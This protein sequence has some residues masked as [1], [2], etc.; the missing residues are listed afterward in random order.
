MLT[1]SIGMG[2]TDVTEHEP[3]YRGTSRSIILTGLQLLDNLGSM[4]EQ[5]GRL[6]AALPRKLIRAIFDHVDSPQSSYDDV[7]DFIRAAAHSQLALDGGSVQDAA[8]GARPRPNDVGTP[9]GE[10][11]L[12]RPSD[13]DLEIAPAA[14]EQALSFL[15]NRLG[16]LTA[17]VR[18]ISNLYT[19]SG[20]PTVGSVLAEVPPVVRRFALTLR[21]RDD[22]ERVPYAHR[23]S[24][25][26][27]AGDDADKSVTRFCDSYLLTE[28]GHGPLVD[29]GLASVR[30]GRV[31]L[32]EAG[33]HVAHSLSPLFD[34]V[35]N[36][37]SIGP[38]A[39]DGLRAALL[40][41]LDEVYE[42]SVVLATAVRNPRQG[43]VDRALTEAHPE[44]TETAIASGRAALLGRLRDLDV[45]SVT[46]RG[47]AASVVPLASAVEFI[48]H[49][50]R[51]AGLEAVDLDEGDSPMESSRTKEGL[52]AD[53]AHAIGRTPPPMSIGSTEPKR[54]LEMVVDRFA[55]DIDKSMSK[56]QLA[57]AIVVA[58]GGVWDDSCDSTS[59]PS[60]G[61]STITLTGLERVLHA[62]NSLR[63][64]RTIEGEPA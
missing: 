62:A 12:A 3:N 54:V 61:G 6:V 55:L 19:D 18:I 56:P 53:I 39:V 52:V 4:D 5:F 45:V 36:G 8:D 27:P 58:A 21:D 11:A 13:R 30:A 48:N 7:S 34:D 35:E 2:I 23:R 28:A 40:D 42:M 60:G 1:F 14:P 63:L 59:S 32:T 15:T 51:R 64:G 38:E 43:Q 50:L 29:A 57:R 17:V 41:N 22:R 16:P 44:W 37:W 47:P 24:T 31:L 26:W 33:L 25:G 9:T 49:V 20:P 46:G 10:A